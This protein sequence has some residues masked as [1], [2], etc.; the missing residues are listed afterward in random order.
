MALQAPACMHES[1]GPTLANTS[2]IIWDL[3]LLITPNLSDFEG[4]QSL[5]LEQ[6]SLSSKESLEISKSKAKAKSPG[7]STISL[8]TPQASRCACFQRG[9]VCSSRT[10][11]KRSPSKPIVLLSVALHTTATKD[12][13]PQTWRCTT[14]KGR[15]RTR[16]DCEHRP[17]K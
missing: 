15:R 6:Q 16:L 5:C 17:R 1:L 11:T 8:A 12:R 9:R 10:P 13:S 3:G 14:L 4:G 7:L 2:P